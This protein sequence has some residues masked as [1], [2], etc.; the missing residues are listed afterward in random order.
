LH[1]YFP[2]VFRYSDPLQPRHEV[3]QL[4][5]LNPMSLDIK[6]VANI[7]QLARLA[8]TEQDMPVYANS[9]SKIL[10]FVEQLNAAEVADVA[11]MAHP[12]AGQVQRMRADE[13]TET[14]AHEK[15]QRNAPRVEASLYLVPK[16]I[17]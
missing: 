7:A 11:P 4:R 5:F 17:E 10:Q 13:V 6:G 16:V 1:G 2:D 9:L 3:G 12:L 14:D 15:F 8:I